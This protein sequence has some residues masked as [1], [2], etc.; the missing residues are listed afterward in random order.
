VEH[1]PVVL[2]FDIGGTNLRLGLVTADNRLVEPHKTRSAPLFA[3]AGPRSGHPLERFGD[4][5]TDYLARALQGRELRAISGG[6]PS[7]VSADRR[8]VISTTNL[9]ALEN[10]P[11]ADLLAGF[12]VPVLVDRDVNNLLRY[13]LVDH[14]LPR[15]GIVVGCYI[16]T[17][18]GNAI[19]INGRILV[20]RHGVAGELGHMPV[21]GES[22]L[23]GCGNRGCVEA[24]AS[25]R[26][27]Q[28]GL[29]AAGATASIGEVFTH[30][31]EA[32]FVQRVLV[33]AAEAVATEIN[34]LDPE[35]V[36]L[37]G[38]V[39]QM[40]GFPRERFEALV[41]N[42]TRKPLPA[43]DTRFL[44]SRNGHHNGVMGAGLAAWQMLAAT[45]REETR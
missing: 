5:L 18:L 4:Y 45:T 22:R 35:A 13:D 31:G 41:R 25:G 11:V 23:C 17:G 43:E 21:H 39:V 8:T 44:Y 2:G 30:C 42:F 20:G 15:D 33:H 34:I 40:K 14:Q 27:L 1:A 3:A 7:T 6:F 36:I 24:V 26:A 16:G 32:D 28:E 10:L 12:G 9:P 19:A 38:G 29:L 37:G